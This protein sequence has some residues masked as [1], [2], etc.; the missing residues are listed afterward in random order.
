MKILNMKC[1]NCGGALEIGPEVSNFTCGYCGSEQFV[2]RQG[3]V[4]Q[5]KLLQKTVSAIQNDT[6]RVADELAVVRLKQEL[7]SLEQK[8]KQEI[9]D[10]KA[11]LLREDDENLKSYLSE[12]K[13][14]KNKAGCGSFALGMILGFGDVFA[15]VILSF[16]FYFIASTI[17][18]FLQKPF[19]SVEALSENK[20]E[21][22]VESRRSKRYDDE[23]K[24]IRSTLAEKL[25]KL[26]Y[27]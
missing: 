13:N 2:E 18:Y 4:V 26:N 14:T 7:E 23:I 27:P 11:L 5:L 15:G 12:I 25:S 10:T 24:R 22:L 3:G 20:F 8:Q 17:N 6:N 1:P 19:D 21:E 9:A 16:M